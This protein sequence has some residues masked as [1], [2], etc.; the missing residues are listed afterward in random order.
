MNSHNVN[1]QKK[2]CGKGLV[3]SI[4]NS[5][6]V[7]LHIPGYQYC[8][9]GTKLAKRLARGDLGINPL[10]AACKQHDIAYSKNQ[11]NLE[12][13]S[14]A[15]KVLAE[16]AWQRVLAR[17]AS[18]GEKAS[19]WGVT[20]IMKAKGKF[21]MGVKKV[22][23]MR[24]MRIIRAAA[25]TAA[26]K[27]MILK[28]A[29]RKLGMGVKKVNNLSLKSIIGAAKK[30]MIH[31]SDPY[32]AITSALKG[33]QAA[34]KRVGSKRK[35][36]TPRV[37]PVPH[38]IGGFLPFL[39]PIFAGLSAAGALS[40]GVASIAKAVNA[41]QEAKRELDESKRHNQSM[42]AIALG[43]GLYLKPYKQGLGLHITPKNGQSRYPA[44]H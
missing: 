25:A 9:P 42:E 14:A 36:R 13:R 22:N 3:N 44:K 4:I 28:K 35:L 5:L 19:A 40:G 18:I 8:G 2:K 11:E 15:D 24:L 31:S 39:I 1:K 23:N 17:D 33:A 20:N 41:A 16:H 7:E 6:P 26:K 38:K 21:G 43:K 34:V 10:D 37:L 12:A 32:M 29:K 30:T 27:T